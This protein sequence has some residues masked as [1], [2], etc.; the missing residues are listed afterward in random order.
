MAHLVDDELFLRKIT[1]PSRVLIRKTWGWF[2]RDGSRWL[3]LGDYTNQ[4]IGDSRPNPGQGQQKIMK[5]DGFFARWASSFDRC[6]IFF[7][8]ALGEFVLCVFLLVGGWALPLWKIWKS[9]G[10]I[11]T[12]PYG[13][14]HFLRRYL[15]PQIIPQTPQTLPTKVLG[16]IGNKCSK[17]PTRWSFPHIIDGLCHQRWSISEIW[18]LACFITLLRPWNDGSI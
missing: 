1:I 3:I 17:P 18:G 5:H 16:S 7:F 6:L 8:V 9:V 15:T 4:Y 12:N 14:K 10:M 2:I 11:I 13:S